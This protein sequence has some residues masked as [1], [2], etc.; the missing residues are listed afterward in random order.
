MLVM[1]SPVARVMAACACVAHWD[2]CHT[3]LQAPAQ[4]VLASSVVIWL[5]P[6]PAID[7]GAFGF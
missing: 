2:P 6:A 3:S 4:L 7:L 5:V 1:A